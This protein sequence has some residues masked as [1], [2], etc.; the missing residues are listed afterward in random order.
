MD[1]KKNNI[2]LPYVE[3]I[4]IKEVSLALDCSIDDIIEWA[5]RDLI[6]L[7]IDTSSLYGELSISCRRD[8]PVI[9]NY[10]NLL[11]EINRKYPDYNRKSVTDFDFQDLFKLL[12][13]N[14]RPLYRGK[15]LMDKYLR[16]ESD[17]DYFKLRF[18]GKG[19]GFW[20]FDYYNLN[21]QKIRTINSQEFFK[22]KSLKLNY[23]YYDAQ[24]LPQNYAKGLRASFLLLDEILVSSDEFYIHNHD[25]NNLKNNKF[26]QGKNDINNIKEKSLNIGKPPHFYKKFAIDT[27]YLTR[28][29]NPQSKV[30]DIARKIH[31]TIIDNFNSANPPT[32]DTISNWLYEIKLGRPTEKNS[33][34]FELVIPDEWCDYSE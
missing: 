8:A 29:R 1:D 15:F 23:K 19:E 32:K 27:A 33:N 7:Y 6:S 22:V 31:F 34:D 13:V 21:R 20:I 17:E 16:N 24:S 9:N 3:A 14:N 4:K 12:P 28:K 2:I 30:A 25:F 5:R 10:I 18:I 11:N 26:V